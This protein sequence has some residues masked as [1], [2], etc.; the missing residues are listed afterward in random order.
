MHVSSSTHSSPQTL[1]TEEPPRAKVKMDITSLSTVSEESSEGEPDSDCAQRKLSTVPANQNAEEVELTSDSPAEVEQSTIQDEGGL[2]STTSSR[3][4][5]SDQSANHDTEEAELTNPDRTDMEQT[6]NHNAGEPEKSVNETSPA[7]RAVHP[8]L[9]LLR[10]ENADSFDI[11]EIHSSE[12]DV[13]LLRSS[14]NADLSRTVSQQ[15]DSSGFAEEPSS[16][17]CLSLKV[18]ESSDSCDSE[19]TVTSHPSQDLATPIAT[20]QPAF[21]LLTGDTGDMGDTQSKEDSKDTPDHAIT[22]IIPQY[23]AHHLPKNQSIS[24]SE[25]Q[26]SSAAGQIRETVDIQKSEPDE[27][28]LSQTSPRAPSLEQ[29]RSE[30]LDLELSRPRSAESPDF[31]SDSSESSLIPAPPSPVLSALKRAKLQQRS[32]GGG[33]GRLRCVPLQRSSSLPT[34]VV[35]SVRIQLGRGRSSCSQPQYT[36]KPQPGEET[37]GRAASHAPLKAIPRH[38]MTTSRSVCS[39]PPSEWQMGSSSPAWSTQ[40]VPELYANSHQH[41]H[42][43]PQQQS[44]YQHPP[45]V[46]YPPVPPH[47][48]PYATPYGS[49]PNLFSPQSPVLP[50]YPN[51]PP[52]STSDH[53]TLSF[54]HGTPHSSWFGGS[55][56]SLHS[57]NTANFSSFSSLSHGTPSPSMSGYGSYTHLHH[58]GPHAHLFMSDIPPPPLHPPQP[59]LGAHPSSLYGAFS[60]EAFPLHHPV[61]S[62][63][64]QLRRVLQDIRGTL[65]S[66]GQ[67]RFGA[68][69]ALPERRDPASSQSVSELL[70]KRRSL[71]AFRSQMMEL[72]LSIVREQAQVYRLLSPTDRLEVE[73]LQRL[74]TA[75]REELQELEQQLEERLMELTPPTR[76]SLEHGSSEE[77]LSSACALRA[78]EPVSDLLREQLLLQSE[79]SYHSNSVSP[80]SSRCCSPIRRTPTPG[81]GVYRAS[82]SITPAPPPRVAGVIPQPHTLQDREDTPTDQGQSR[83]AAATPTE[84]GRSQEAAATPPLNNLQQ[85]IREIRQSVA[86]EVRREIYSELLASVSPAKPPL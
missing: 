28:Q 70:L 7:D 2:D 19:T 38:L 77:R 59:A 56:S 29:N 32:P 43:H 79:L 39:S 16:D 81:T 63:E 83:E 25:Q 84:Q 82:I 14:R 65:H 74:R 3:T 50:S 76:T 51:Y 53:P 62:S 34:T 17:S 78:M 54:G 67:S 21:A 57:P 86:E 40:S 5:D 1:D 72:E 48:Y 12:D 13:V 33:R 31:F 35:S 64:M 26:S 10:T 8:Q 22:D 20:D 6:A 4:E 36:R 71:N 58:P 73:Q 60:P 18:Q 9:A 47:S 66:L 85:L 68:A 69:D 44:S 55:S 49:L 11:E 52:H 42:P 27:G 30:S 46:S 45:P 15:S 80:A 41:H 23:S 37:D 24:S 75:V 61:S